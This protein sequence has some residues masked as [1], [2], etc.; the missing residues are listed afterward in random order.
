M[1]KTHVDH[2]A[3]LEAGVELAKEQIATAN[4]LK[5]A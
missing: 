1:R 5:A 3:D 4:E 2:R